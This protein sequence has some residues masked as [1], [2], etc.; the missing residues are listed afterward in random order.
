MIVSSIKPV[1]IN[2]FKSKYN[3]NPI[4]RTDIVF[5]LYIGCIYSTA[6]LNIGYL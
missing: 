6:W 5:T 2:T 4:V 1:A 3:L